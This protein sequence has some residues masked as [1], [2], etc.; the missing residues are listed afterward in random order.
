ML[1]EQEKPDL[2][3][4]E[5]FKAYKMKLHQAMVEKQRLPYNIKVMMAKDRIREF[6]DEA[7]RMQLLWKDYRTELSILILFPL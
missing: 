7:K 1:I 4:K 2:S 6:Y 5:L 3:S